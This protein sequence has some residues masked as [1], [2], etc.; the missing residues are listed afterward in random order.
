[1]LIRITRRVVSVT[2][3]LILA[4]ASHAS[5][6]LRVLLDE[7]RARQVRSGS[8]VEVAEW[9][10]QWLTRFEQA[11][12]EAGSTHPVYGRLGLAGA[13]QYRL[14]GLPE[15]ALA[16][17]E[18]LTSTSGSLPVRLDAAEHA[19]TIAATE[20]AD[21]AA[22]EN[23]LAQYDLVLTQVSPD[24][25]PEL[26]ERF[27]RAPYVKAETWRLLAE[28]TTHTQRMGNESSFEAD[29]AARIFEQASVEYRSFVNLVEQHPFVAALDA[30]TFNRLLTESRNARWRA[31]Q[32]LAEAAAN[33]EGF[34]D[35]EAQRLHAA[36]VAAYEVLFDWHP[37]SAAR[38]Q[39]VLEYFAELVP[40]LSREAFLRKAEEFLRQNEFPP[41]H[42]VI[43]FLRSG[44]M[45]LSNDDQTLVASNA[46]FDLIIRL[47]REWFPD[48]HD[49]HANY[50][51]ALI[52]SGRNAL[53]LGNVSA[54][55]DRLSELEGLPLRSAAM[56]DSMNH[57]ERMY[58]RYAARGHDV[59]N[60]VE[61][62]DIVAD[63]TSPAPPSSS[64][65]ENER[66]DEAGI[67]PT[68]GSVDADNGGS[69]RSAEAPARA[70][71]DRHEILWALLGAGGAIVALIG[72]F[73][74]RQIMRR[75]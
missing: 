72:F 56:Q 32:S 12:P 55:R 44:A 39:I 63:P 11:W 47:E 62:S 4:S 28:Y 5:D 36:S 20:L 31:A 48:E 73:G 3:A 38:E 41:S 60:L 69:G 64:S 67:G 9:R 18:R 52:R 75:D 14:H 42:G 8:S 46:L 51:I 10:A 74:L 68:N 59:G 53:R 37:E 58:E 16:V 61:E 19:I 57:L 17:L 13:E 6:D 27:L 49:N 30:T 22:L 40:T 29:L 26:L 2:F 35:R 66:V 7:Q 23:Y 54:A 71:D 43:L 45:H 33:L 50:Q 1:M 21:L 24:A 25:S 15:S 65:A 70:D 34:S